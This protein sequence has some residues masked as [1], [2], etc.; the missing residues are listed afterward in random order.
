MVVGPQYIVRAMFV[1]VYIPLGLVSV[2]TG[3]YEF[4]QVSLGNNSSWILAVPF[5]QLFSF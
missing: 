5:G 4:L 1:F 3:M 2:F